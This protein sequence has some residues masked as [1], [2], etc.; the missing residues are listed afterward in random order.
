MQ[1][2]CALIIVLW[3]SYPHGR[4]PMH[5]IYCLTWRHRHKHR[6]QLWLWLWSTILQSSYR[7]VQGERR[8]IWRHSRVYSI[9]N[10]IGY[11]ILMRWRTWYAYSIHLDMLYVC[12]MY[13]VNIFAVNANIWT[14]N[15][16]FDRA[17][18]AY[19]KTVECFRLFIAMTWLTLCTA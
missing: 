15:I 5:L 4:R 1:S 10:D 12:N 13:T 19:F 7:W 16:P 11:D 8:I 17:S 3:S 14:C 6:H 9:K 18:L 2:C